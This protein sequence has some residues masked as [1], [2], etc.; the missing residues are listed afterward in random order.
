VIGR[1]SVFVYTRPKTRLNACTLCFS[2]LTHCCHC[3]ILKVVSSTSPHARRRHA[4][5]L[6]HSCQI[7]CMCNH[8]TKV[9]ARKVNEDTGPS[10]TSANT[11]PLHTAIY[12]VSTPTLPATNAISAAPTPDPSFA[13][14]IRILFSPFSPIPSISRK[15]SR[16]WSSKL[17]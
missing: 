9:F 1:K 17:G 8:V 10:Y 14:P 11:S 7:Y 2:M 5:L 15:A 13:M 3:K 12:S 16:I 4:M 6:I